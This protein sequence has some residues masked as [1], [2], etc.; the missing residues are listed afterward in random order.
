MSNIVWTLVVLFMAA[1]SQAQ[2]RSLATPLN[3]TEKINITADTLEANN[4]DRSFLF[5]GNVKVVQGQ[6]EVTSDAL[7]IR[8]RAPQASEKEE[9]D[10]A[11]GKLEKIEATGNVVILFDGRTAK[12]DKA[13]YLGD[14]EI[15]QLIGEKSTVI[16]GP[17]TIVGSKITLY[18]T[19]D[20]IKVESSRNN[21]S[22]RVTATF[23]PG[24]DK[25]E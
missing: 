1:A 10:A 15:L 9:T 19:E 25:T 22:D 23:F 18:R 5:K 13:V 3:S 2:E 12:T 6:T 14:Q 4:K 24:D 17:N 8:Y 11:G 16:D 7:Y 20:R 21:P